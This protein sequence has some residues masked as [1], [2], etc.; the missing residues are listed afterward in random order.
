LRA[1][2]DFYWGAQRSQGIALDALIQLVSLGDANDPLSSAVI[3][4][5]RLLFRLTYVSRRL[6]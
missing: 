2:V 4:P 5:P 3:K 1:G 6:D